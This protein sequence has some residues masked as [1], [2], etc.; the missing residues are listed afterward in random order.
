MPKPFAILA[1]A[2]AWKS[3]STVDLAKRS[4]SQD[5]ARPTEELTIEERS[6]IAYVE[7]DDSPEHYCA[8]LDRFAG[9]LSPDSEWL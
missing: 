6:R 8:S 5:H 7:P 4:T 2:L 9:R 3:T 1:A